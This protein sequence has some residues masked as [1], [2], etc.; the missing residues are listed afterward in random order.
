MEIHSTDKCV[1][2]GR[3]YVLG[4]TSILFGGEILIR[5]TKFLYEECDQAELPSLY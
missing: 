3:F 2:R 1:I 4:H 5:L